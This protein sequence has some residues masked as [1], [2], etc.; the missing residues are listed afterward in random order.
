M[1]HLIWDIDIVAANFLKHTAIVRSFNE[2]PINTIIE[3]LKLDKVIFEIEETNDSIKFF[4]NYGTIWETKRE[5]ERT[6]IC[7]S[8]NYYANI[9][10]MCDS[11]LSIIQFLLDESGNKFCVEEVIGK[12]FLTLIETVRSNQKQ[13][14]CKN[15]SVDI[16]KIKSYW[17][18][19]ESGIV[20][21]KC[22]RNRLNSAFI[23]SVGTHAFCQECE[24]SLSYIYDIRPWM[25]LKGGRKCAI[26]GKK[27]ALT[28][29]ISHRLSMNYAMM[30][31]SPSIADC[32]ITC[33]GEGLKK[34][35]YDQFIKVYGENDEAMK[36]VSRYETKA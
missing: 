23:D 9:I 32:L 12:N 1:K 10:R 11:V 21:E 13:W 29:L 28:C 34:E 4:C 33:Y 26:T 19:M 3:K 15:N 31:L 17:D 27:D 16:R 30:D 25:H 7:E 8:E 5:S 35:E 14:L 2:I 20:C 18:V 22:G 6:K 24:Q 36:F